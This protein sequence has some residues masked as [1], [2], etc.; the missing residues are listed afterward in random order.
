[1]NLYE[2]LHTEN[3]THQGY[4]LAFAQQK[5]TQIAAANQENNAVAPTMAV[6]EANEKII[7][8]I[9]LNTVEVGIYHFTNAEKQ[10]I[11]NIANTCPIVAGPVCYRVGCL[12]SV[13]EPNVDYNDIHL[14]QQVGIAFRK[15][16]PAVTLEAK[17]TLFPNPANSTITISRTIPF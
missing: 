3:A 11:N 13:Y 1:M 12:R 5:A 6:Y 15:P 10:A 9:M 4:L 7:N 16:R 17:Y 14:C 8:E 2:A